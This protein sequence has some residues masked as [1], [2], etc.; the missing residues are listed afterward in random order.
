MVIQMKKLK[1]RKDTDYIYPCFKAKAPYGEYWVE[2]INELVWTATFY[3]G[4]KRAFGGMIRTL[5]DVSASGE[6][7]Y[8]EAQK[9]CQ[10]DFEKELINFV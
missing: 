8:L 5:H 1:F 7:G 2:Y 3:Y 6:N 10:A 4:G 9:A